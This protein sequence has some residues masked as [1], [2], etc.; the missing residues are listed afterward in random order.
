MT[1][2]EEFKKQMFFIF[3]TPGTFGSFLYHVLV[4]SDK[5]TKYY[6]NSL[7]I[8]DQNNAAHKNTLDVIN[9]FHNDEEVKIWQNLKTIEEKNNYFIQNLNTEVK[10][11]QLFQPPLRVATLLAVDDIRK[12]APTSKRILIFFEKKSINTV[13][14]IM[15][16][17]VKH[18]NG[19]NAITN[20][21][22]ICKLPKN[23]K[24]K[25]I[26]LFENSK[27]IT[28]YYYDI[29]NLV[30]VKNDEAVFY[31]ENFFTYEKFTK[32]LQEILD[33]FNLSVD[34]DNVK[35]LYE[36][37]YNVNVKYFNYD[38]NMVQLVVNENGL[39]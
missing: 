26:I 35:I 24:R 13:S 9:N 28:Q 4:L 7:D 30:D 12:F 17:K 5:F 34:M 2:L 20:Y 25:E 15:G 31:F 8:F 18:T 27:K 11:I 29:S 16:E 21:K 36:R 6:N 1:D 10:D 3:Y 37:F 23:E 19:I 22:K 33:K 39:A 32:N 38:K 14:K